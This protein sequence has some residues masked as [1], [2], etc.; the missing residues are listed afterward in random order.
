VLV[1][2]ANLKLSLHDRP[3]LKGV[4]L[5]MQVGEIYGLLGP[6]GAGK[7]TTLSVLTG[8][9]AAA[10][11]RVSVA[12]LDPWS[13]RKEVHR[14][15][16][17]LP[18]Q[19]GFYDWMSAPDYLGWFASLYGQKLTGADIRTHLVQVGLSA[20]NRDPIGTYSRGMRQRLGLART[21][22]SD[23]QLLVLDEPT[24]GLDPRGRREI[25]DVLLDLT[26]RHGVGVLL[27]T[28][29]LD[30]VDRLCNRIGIIH[31]GKTM[32]EGNLA[33]LLVTQHTAVRYR[34]RILTTS[35]E[36]ALVPGTKVVAKG[37][38]WWHLD[39]GAELSPHLVWREMMNS[40]WEI[41]EIHSEGG[42]LEE[43]YL[44]LTA[45]EAER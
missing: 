13:Q 37:G 39:I 4:N 35:P 43:L 27:C 15:I 31:Q 3:I 36:G 22:L 21:L 18:E 20:D 19:T 24:N 26:Q 7:S 1:E 9:R 41:D 30:D 32:L 2:I 38:E 42:G 8:L 25:H 33:E 44:N 14:K 45:T 17:V 16:G 12:D 23:P 40:G 29:L 6:N 5:H 34:L 11:G 10:S 28:H